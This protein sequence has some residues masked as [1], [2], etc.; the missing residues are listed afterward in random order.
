[1]IGFSISA[2]F[3][4]KLVSFLAILGVGLGSGLLVTLLSLSTGI[5]G[6]FSETFQSLSGTITVTTEGSGLLGRLLGNPGDPLPSS[7]IK[8]VESLEGIDLVAPYVAAS[9]RVKEFGAL[10]AIGVGL[11]GIEAGDEL[12][13]SPRSHITEGRDFTGN[14]EVILGAR[15][16]DFTTLSGEPLE[17]G[18]VFTVPVGASGETIEV[19]LVGIFETGQSTNDQGVL[20]SPALV[21]KLG[22]LKN[23]QVSGILARAANPEET[24][25]LAEA[26][27]ER[28]KGSDPAISASVPADLFAGFSSFF[29]VFNFFLL[30]IA[31]VAAFAGGIAVMVVMLL[32][33]FERRKEFGILKAAGWSNGNL[34]FSVLLTSLT[35]SILGAGLGLL[36]GSG[37][38]LAI[39]SQVE[40]QI[41][42]F[43]PQTFFWAGGVGLLTGVL[44]G[45]VP[46]LSAARVSPI[47]TLR[48]E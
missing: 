7:Y 32:S 45:I 25:V 8:R 44:G 22:G 26:L 34:I 18:D 42:G 24:Q 41:V 23:T 48:G 20:G 10:G 28:F 33:S 30:G 35:L 38:A 3:R 5:R 11:T 37:A 14:R 40:Q 16:L 27:E 13:G 2:A 17:V 47:E 6:L 4:R 36:L 46:A 43:A 31:L 39:Q 15:I 9:M 12:F 19:K 21:R 29:N 1:M